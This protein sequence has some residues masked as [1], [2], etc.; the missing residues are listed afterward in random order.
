MLDF[1]VVDWDN[2]NFITAEQRITMERRRKRS[3]FWKQIAIPAIIIGATVIFCI[4]M[5]KFGMDYSESLKNPGNV[6][7]TP[8][9]S[10]NHIAQPPD[11]PLISDVLPS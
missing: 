10:E 2:M 6:Q 5:M 3:D 1:E 4:V 7:N 11:I 9:N 8:V